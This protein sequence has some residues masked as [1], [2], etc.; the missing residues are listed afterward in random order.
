M[1]KPTFLSSMIAVAVIGLLSLLSAATQAAAQGRSPQALAHAL[2]QV[3]EVKERHVQELME[4]L[5]VV[6]AGIGFNQQ[7]EAA[8]KVFVQTHA[9]IA[10][11]PQLLDG[12]PVAVKVT[13]KIVAMGCPQGTNSWD[14]AARCDRPVPIGVSTGH[15]SVTA[16]TIG[17]RVKDSSGNIYALSNNHVYAAE[18]QAIIGAPVYQPGVY[19]GGLPSD[20]IGNLHAFEPIRFCTPFFIF[21]ICQQ[22]NTID[23][24]IA[25][26]STANLGKSTPPYGYGAPRSDIFGDNNPKDGVIDNVSALVGLKVQKCGR[27]TGCT[28]GT[29]TAVNATIDVGYGTALARFVDQF[30]VESDNGMPVIG[31]GDSG[32]LL[33]AQDPHPVGLLFAGS[34]D[35]MMAVANRIDHV[36]NRFGVTVDGAGAQPPPPDTFGPVTSLVNAT[37][38]PTQGASSVTLTATVNDSTTGGS[39]VAGAEYFINSVG[40]NGAGTPMNASDGS[41]NSV[42]EGVTAAVNVTGYSGPITL[43]VRGKDSQNNWGAVASVVLNVTAAPPPGPTQVA[44]HD[45]NGSWAGGTGWSG[46]WT[47]SGDTSIV[48]SGS[49]YSGSYHLRLRRSTGYAARSVNLGSPAYLSFCAKVNSFESTDKGEVIING[50]VVKTFTPADS[51]NTYRCF[52]NAGEFPLP[53]GNVTIA[54][55]AGMSSQSDY[56]YIDDVKVWR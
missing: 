39:V 5:G 15:P 25:M 31:G 37:P 1:S 32:S 51:N 35:G 13:G 29:I 27:T 18:N 26:S 49:A 16:G 45:F 7:G 55:D 17:A 50:A 46:P 21:W 8:I 47:R 9:D 36:L 4:R 19:D 33:V 23:A 44:F 24:A 48:T 3:K 38:N 6:G 20:T 11:V 12:V 40:A 43:Y 34:G 14:P 53:A 10:R 54:F 52:G 42:T 28:T 56:W 22:T 41:F 30:I 2:A